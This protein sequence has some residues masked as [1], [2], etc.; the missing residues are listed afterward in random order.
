[1]IASGVV[2]VTPAEASSDPRKIC[3]EQTLQALVGLLE[4]AVPTIVL[5]VL[6]HFYLKAML[7]GPL[8]KIMKE[9]EALT[10]GARQGAENSLAAAERKTAEY[11]AKLREARAEIY[12]EQEEIRRKWLDEQTGQ[13]DQA[14]DRIAAAVRSARDQ[15]AREAAAA[16]T[17]L[18]ETSGQLADRIA[19]TILQRRPQ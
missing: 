5:L 10:K 8:A 7:F 11:E 9:R 18:L 4:K 17:S 3:M 15:I 13:V 14:R 6:L 2:V 19:S 12:R 1:V 16:R